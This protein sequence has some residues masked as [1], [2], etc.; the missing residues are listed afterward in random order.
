[1]RRLQSVTVRSSLTPISMSV[2]VI[3]SP[4]LTVMVQESEKLARF[5]NGDTAVALALL[6]GVTLHTGAQRR[7]ANPAVLIDNDQNT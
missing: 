7:V 5:P 6:T 3:V 4:A 1:M 2:K